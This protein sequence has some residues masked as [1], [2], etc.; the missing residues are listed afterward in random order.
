MPVKVTDRDK[1]YAKMIANLDAT[2]KLAITVGIHSEEGEGD[3][4]GRSI[5]DIAEANEFGLGVPARPFVSGWADNYP[6]PVG[7]MRDEAAAA[8][9][10]GVSP[11]K[12][13]DALAQVWAGDMQAEISA[14]IDPENAE[15]TIERKGS[16]T[17]LIDTGILRSS[18]RGKVGA[19]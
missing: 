1:G 10:A 3:H 9:K 4:D 11:T 16:S 7:E 13:L 19:K 8:L 14:G 6:D 15:S 18:I 17:P 12:R 2:G 5:V